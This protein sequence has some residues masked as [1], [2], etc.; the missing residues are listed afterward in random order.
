MSLFMELAIWFIIGW[1]MGIIYGWNPKLLFG[2]IIIMSLYV[3][4][5]Y[6]MNPLIVNEG[7]TIWWKNLLHIIIG[8]IGFQIGTP[9]FK[10]IWGKK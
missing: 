3:I 2:L 1:L 9:T 7:N 4:I 6:L 5:S 8:V 10:H